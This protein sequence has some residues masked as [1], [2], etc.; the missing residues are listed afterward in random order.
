MAR[1]PSP[2]DPHFMNEAAWV[3]SRF[4]DNAMNS[5]PASVHQQ[6]MQFYSPQVPTSSAS[7]SDSHYSPVI[8]GNSDSEADSSSDHRPSRRR[9]LFKW[10][11]RHPKA[12]VYDPRRSANS[13]GAIQTWS[14]KPNIASRSVSWLVA[15]WARFKWAWKKSL[16]RNEE[17]ILD[18][19][20]GMA[21][22]G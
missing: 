4:D 10:I 15:E 21:Y 5:Y 1:S 18:P 17:P 12:K 8:R 2:D 3:Y 22:V 14:P 6:E 7:Q 19:E 13:E 9:H 20:L 11:H 16:G